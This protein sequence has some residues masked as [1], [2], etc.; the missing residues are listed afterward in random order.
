MRE[1]KTLRVLIVDDHDL[2]R[3][4]LSMIMSRQR[5]LQL[6]GEATCAA[7]A[8]RKA[9][10]LQPDV[11]ILALRLPDGSGIEVCR[12]IRSHNPTT[13]VL[14]LTSYSDDEAVVGSIIA[15]A[16]GYLLKEIRA[17]E[18]I[19]A[20]R[21][22]GR[23]QSLLDPA[24]AERALQRI[25]QGLRAGNRGQLTPLEQQILELIADGQ[26][27]RE[28]AARLSLSD[29]AVKE[30]VSAILSNLEVTRRSQAAAYVVERQMRRSARR[31]PLE[32]SSNT[33]TSIWD[34]IR[35]VPEE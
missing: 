16:S 9:I 21:K 18:T 28:I 7:E 10:D 23:G 13:K 4:C 6:V 26:T 31:G 11:V 20:I 2:V 33:V 12:E 22:A 32:N 29:Q 25:R 34:A 19:N 27:D 15:G 24:I 14:M 1:E 8:R 3:R 17:G 35:G 5:E 30:H